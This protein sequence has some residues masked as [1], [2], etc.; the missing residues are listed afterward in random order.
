MPKLARRNYSP[1][2]K[3]LIVGE[4]QT[5]SRAGAGS[6]RVIAEG[7]GVRESAY[8]TWLKAGVCPPSAPAAP[9]RQRFNPTERQR[10]LADIE[11]RINGGATAE[12][13]CQAAGIT[14]R[15]YRAWRSQLLSPLMR[16]VEVTALVPATPTGVATITF[17]PQSPVPAAPPLTLHAPGGYRV[18]GL[19]VASLAAILKALQC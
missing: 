4:I 13:A 2:E 19:D 7:L 3:A 9:T 15:T 14:T 1:A 10:I 5:R 8:Y 16:P 11:A 12:S 18:E 6:I 17:A